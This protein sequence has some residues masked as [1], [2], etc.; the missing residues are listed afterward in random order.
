[1]TL[2]YMLPTNPMKKHLAESIDS[3]SKEGNYYQVFDSYKSTQLDNYTDSLMYMNA[4]YDGDE[5]A[6]EK[7]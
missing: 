4:I 2:V 5:S 1:M 7:A 6:F 3:L